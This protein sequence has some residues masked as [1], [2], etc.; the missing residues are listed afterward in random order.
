MVH[1]FNENSLKS[2]PVKFAIFVKRSRI[3]VVRFEL[4]SGELL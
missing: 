1:D 2:I 3:I 4:R